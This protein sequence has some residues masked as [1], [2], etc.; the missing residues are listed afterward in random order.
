MG[1][2]TIAPSILAC[3]FGALREEVRAVERAGADWIH[4]DVM[5]GQFVPNLTIG[6]AIVR[7]IDRSTRLPLDVHLMLEHPEQYDERFIDAGADHL[8]V[9]IEAA[10]LRG[11]ARMTRFLRSLRRRKV[12]AGLSLR[13]RTAASS[14]KPFLQEVDQIL[15]MTVEPGFGGQAFMP[16]MIGKIKRLRGW[17]DGDIAVDGGINARTAKLTCQAGA[18]VL[19]AGTSIFGARGYAAAIRALRG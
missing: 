8:T 12:R 10:G 14:L 1:T 4:V 3:D 15:V 6:P 2:A 9:H 17:F 7:A 18:N 19:V 11:R 13:P 16:G 5:D